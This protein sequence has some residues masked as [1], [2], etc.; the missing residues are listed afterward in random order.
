MEADSCNQPHQGRSI[1]LRPSHGDVEGDS[2]TDDEMYAGDT[3]PYNLTSGQN[4]GERQVAEDDG[5]TQAI[6]DEET[7]A[8]DD[9]ET[10][11]IYDGETQAI[12]DGETQAIDDGETQAIYDGETQAID[13]GET[14]AIYD[15]ETQA[16][17]DGETQVVDDWQTQGADER[18]TQEADDWEMQKG[19]T[20]ARPGDTGKAQ[21]DRPSSP[22]K[23]EKP[24]QD[25]NPS[26]SLTGRRQM[27]RSRTTSL[28][29]EA[30][31]VG[32]GRGE[33][34]KVLE[35]LEALKAE[36]QK[37][38][39]TPVMQV[40]SRT[41][42]CVRLLEE[43]KASAA[44]MGEKLKTMAENNAS[45]K[46]KHEEEQTVSAQLRNNEKDLRTQLQASETSLIGLQSELEEERR[47]GKRL[48]SREREL[49][50]IISNAR[51]ILEQGKHPNPTNTES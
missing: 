3:V 40:P 35:R 12:Y 38:L 36:I 14:Q 41:D 30:E 26:M 16:I 4:G 11:A 9:E 15:G 5:E 29:G 31:D 18:K 1:S 13:D 47:E 49:V 27:A 22:V 10:Q 7:Q 45:L 25:G 28:S 19:D 46:R 17:Y 2:T 32:E 50:E 24:D 51:R 8:I 33:G 6:D 21:D 34:V 48:K 44:S 20:N 23:L 42:E 37:L 43:C 39:L